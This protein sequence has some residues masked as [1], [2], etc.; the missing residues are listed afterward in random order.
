LIGSYVELGEIWLQK[1]NW[2]EAITI[3]QQG[4]QVDAEKAILYGKLGKAFYNTQ[5]WEEALAN[6]QKAI[7]LEPT[8]PWYYQRIGDIWCILQNWGKAAKAYQQWEQKRKDR[9]RQKPTSVMVKPLATKSIPY[10]RIIYGAYKEGGLCN[11]LRVLASCLSLGYFWQ[12]PVYMRWL[13]AKPCNCRF[14]DLYQPVCETVEAEEVERW[15]AEEPSETLHIDTITLCMKVLYVKYLK[16]EVDFAAYESKYLEIIR[17]LILQPSLQ[18]A[19]DDFIQATWKHPI[20]GLHVRRTDHDKSQYISSD[21][22]FFQTMERHLQQGVETFFLATDN[23]QTQ[24]KFK[25]RFGDRIITYSATFNPNQQRQTSQ[26]TATIDLH[27][28][29]NT[30][31]I[32]GS[33]GSSFGEYA[34]ALGNI[35]LE[36]PWE[37]ANA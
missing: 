14:E 20:V 2:Q 18:T 5:K 23:G 15:L 1:E 4:L 34:A 33:Y 3:L 25:Q 30:Q 16:D 37:T 36:L 19:V 21:E 10:H 27:L 26:Q 24:A 7:E 22:R 9:E 17:S 29:A 28:L 31:K 11:R 12:I 32:I 35:P 13:P 8:T 6:L